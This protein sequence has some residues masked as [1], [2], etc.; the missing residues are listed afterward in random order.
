MYFVWAWFRVWWRSRP[1]TDCTVSLPAF[2]RNLIST[3]SAS[4]NSRRTSIVYPRPLTAYSDGWIGAGWASKWREW[5]Q[6]RGIIL[7]GSAGTIRSR[8]NRLPM[9]RYSATFD[10]SG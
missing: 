4:P 1:M 5:S 8:R 2:K 9:A 10:R 7:L 3:K 6:P